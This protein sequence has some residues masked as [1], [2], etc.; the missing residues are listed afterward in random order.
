[1]K[2]NNTD[3]P[4]KTFTIYGIQGTHYKAE[5]KAK[6]EEQALKLAENNHEDY[7]W[8]ET[9]YIDDWNYESE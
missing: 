7:E 4:N 5:I 3:K 9:D 6:S 2:V 1:M 8:E